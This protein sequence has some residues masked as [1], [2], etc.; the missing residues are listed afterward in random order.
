MLPLEGWGFVGVSGNCAY[1]KCERFRLGYL[2]RNVPRAPPESFLDV[3]PQ[4]ICVYP[5]TTPF[6]KYGNVALKKTTI[7]LQ[8]QQVLKVVVVKV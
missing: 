8:N 1:L 7:K 5:N 2:I 6:D 4:H 3:N